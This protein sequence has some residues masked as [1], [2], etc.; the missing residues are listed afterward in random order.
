MSVAP[1]ADSKRMTMPGLRRSLFARISRAFL[2]SA[3]AEAL[4]SSPVS[5]LGA[6]LIPCERLGHQSVARRRE[7]SFDHYVERHALTMQPAALSF[8][9]LSSSDSRCIFSVLPPLQVSDT[10]RGVAGTA[11]G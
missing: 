7:D 5:A 4:S 1:R 3:C 6:Q 9:C 10:I 8:I 11:R 2:S